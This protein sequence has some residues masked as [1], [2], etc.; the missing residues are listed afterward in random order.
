MYTDEKGE[1]GDIRRDQRLGSGSELH[2]L[3]SR[4]L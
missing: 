1:G 2:R 4:L 3:I